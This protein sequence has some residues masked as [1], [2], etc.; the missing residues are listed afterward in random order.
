MAAGPLGR[1]EADAGSPSVRAGNGSRAGPVPVAQVAQQEQA[2]RSP[3]DQWLADVAHDSNRRLT[4]MATMEAQ[5]VCDETEHLAVQHGQALFAVF[6]RH[7]GKAKQMPLVATLD[8]AEI[9]YDQVTS[10]FVAKAELVIR[11]GSLQEISAY[12]M[13]YDSRHMQARLGDVDI[14]DELREIVNP[15]HLVIFYYCF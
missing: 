8:K 5:H 3:H 14:R 10:T 13:E 7:D 2:D 11:G 15:H 12:L 1:P 4:R 6:G 9:K